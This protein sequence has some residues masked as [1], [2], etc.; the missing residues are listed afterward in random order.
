[1]LIHIADLVLNRPLLVTPDKAQ[2]IVSVLAGRDE[3][4]G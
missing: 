2:V 4:Q 1:M 3:R